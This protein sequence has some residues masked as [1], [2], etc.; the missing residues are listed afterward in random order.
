M[1]DAASL[2][3][4]VKYAKVVLDDSIP[5]LDIGQVDLGYFSGGARLAADFINTKGWVSGQEWLLSAEDVRPFFVALGQERRVTKADIPRLH[6]LRDRLRAVF[7]A[8]DAGQV[9]RLID[10]LLVDF[11]SQPRFER[12]GELGGLGFEPVGNDAASLIGANAALGLAFFI[13]EN[14]T[15]RLGI[16]GASDCDDAYIDESKNST[17][18]CCSPKCTR[19]E[20]VRAFRA[21]RRDT[22][23]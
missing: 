14:G 5:V 9:R 8:T 7:L 4:G 3:G 2:P 11:P 17:K 1:R 19:L 22:T 6:A 23:A 15:A 10:G 21:R 16:C 13:A 12:E 20:N 18:H